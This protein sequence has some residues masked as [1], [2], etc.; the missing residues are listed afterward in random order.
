MNIF[1]ARRILPVAGEI[2]L[3]GRTYITEAIVRWN[4]TFPEFVRLGSSETRF[5]FANQCLPV[6]E[7][8]LTDHKYRGRHW[9]GDQFEFGG[10]VFD[11][12][13]MEAIYC[14]I[15]YHAGPALFM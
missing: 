12:E 2:A 7:A 13:E 10:H 6:L 9:N 4:P 14:W 8:V 3:A 11:V 1:K 15:Q 5:H